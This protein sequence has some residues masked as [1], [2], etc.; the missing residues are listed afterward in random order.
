[1][2]YLT[3]VTAISAALKGYKTYLASA[4]AIL[5][6]LA[7]LAGLIP[8]A[9]AQAIALVFGGIAAI[10]LRLSQSDHALTLQEALDAI[11]ELRKLVNP[12]RPPL[13]TSGLKQ[14]PP[15]TLKFPRSGAA[16]LLLVLALSS[17]AAAAPPKAVIEGTDP[18]ISGEIVVL[19]GSSSDGLPTN[20]SW[21]ITPEIKG[22]RNLLYLDGGKRVVTHSF[23]GD[24]LVELIVSNADGHSRAIRQLHIPGTAPPSPTPQPTPPQ[25]VPPGPVPPVNPPGPAPGPAPTPPA[26]E[27]PALTGLSLSAYNAAMAVT[28]DKRASEALCLANGCQS[29]SSSLA[30][31]KFTGLSLVI[32]QG[33]VAEMGQV[34]DRCTSPP[35]T[36]CR[37]L[38]AAKIDSLWKAGSLK[39][40]AD[41]KQV[42][43]QIE[44]GLRRVK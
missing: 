5:T 17:V 24:Y 7:G 14:D 13:D 10:C 8:N 1:M 4:A 15:A 3:I 16:A 34:M 9:D 31:G 2:Q 33:V 20:F 23:P 22:R 44:V 39:T 28:S 36:D 18:S 35:W 43:D 11:D 42:L 21:E 6:S 40:A 12:P 29:L 19:D 32:A 26:P 30:A 41:W 37:E 27:P 38:I 25:P